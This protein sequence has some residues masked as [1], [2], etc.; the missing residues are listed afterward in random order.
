M[1]GHGG[2][3]FLVEISP[4]LTENKNVFLKIY[5]KKL[6]RKTAVNNRINFDITDGMNDRWPDM[7]LDF[8]LFIYLHKIW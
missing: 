1:S 7:V 5:R 8:I 4:Q 6:I 3:V 2:T